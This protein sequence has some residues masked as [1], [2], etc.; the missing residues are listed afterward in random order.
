[1]E[2]S[3]QGKGGIRVER[4]RQRWRTSGLRGTFACTHCFDKYHQFHAMCYTVC[5]K[6]YTCELQVLNES[7]L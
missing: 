6:E 7:T 5:M 2:W 1:M 4:A 3:V